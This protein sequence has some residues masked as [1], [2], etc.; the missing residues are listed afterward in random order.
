LTNKAQKT[1]LGVPT[2]VHERDPEALR[3]IIEEL[4]ATEFPN[5]NNL[6]VTEIEIPTGAGVAN[7]TLLLTANWQEEGQTLSEGF[8]MRLDSNDKLFPEPAFADHFRLYDIM[9]RIGTVPA[10]RVLGLNL[11][12]SP[13]GR[14]Y[15][16]MERIAG[17]VPSDQPP[18]HMTGW[19]TEKT[20]LER[21]T[22]WRN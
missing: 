15:F 8:V 10:P 20:E 3:S 1:D 5:R 22:M 12:R 14:P 19:V 9:K 17:R 7:E 2:K 6:R 16:F 13:V 4:L 11:D 18:F 21:Q